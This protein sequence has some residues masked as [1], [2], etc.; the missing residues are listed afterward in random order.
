MPRLTT[1]A[2][3][4]SA[5][6]LSVLEAFG[7]GSTRLT[8]SDLS[9]RTGLPL[10][11]THRLVGE[12]TTWGAL[13]RD[14]DGRYQIGL[15]LWEIGALAPRGHGLRETA[16]PFLEDLYEATHQNVQLAVLDGHEAVFLER[17]SGREAVHVFTRVGGRLPVHATGV[18]LVLLAHAPKAVQEEVIAGPL[19]RFTEK[20]IP[21][22][23]ALRRVLADVRR[24]GFAI[25]NG[26]I[27]LVA[28]SVAAPVHGPDDSV[29]AAISLV[30][31]S[32]DSD[33]YALLTAVRAAARGISRALGSPSA[34][35]VPR[36][37]R[38]ETFS[39]P[40]GL[41]RR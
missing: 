38:R 25:S 9:R 17:L 34:R 14:A 21:N 1:P 26:Q 13:E 36:S 41:R 37:V 20:T 29:I 7:P 4:V 2:P 5:R 15:R 30:V 39:A 40:E 33:A 32:E 22:G 23:P 19:K 35:R 8:L 31:P 16:M 27:E 3:S 10:T 6:L 24:Q 12:L 28:L 11:T 18:G